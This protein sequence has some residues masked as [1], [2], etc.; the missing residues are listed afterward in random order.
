MQ[1]IPDLPS[2]E[3]PVENNGNIGLFAFVAAFLSNLLFCMI[4]FPALG[5]SPLIPMMTC[6]PLTMLLGRIIAIR[7]SEPHRDMALLAWCLLAA[8]AA[9][10]VLFL[11]PGLADGIFTEDKS[12]EQIIQERHD[13]VWVAD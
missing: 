1:S 10:A 2:I 13:A 6:F 8:G 5:L 11:T 4:A 3:K 9:A 12:M 7:F